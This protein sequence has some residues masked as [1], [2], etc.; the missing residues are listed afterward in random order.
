[1]KNKFTEYLISRREITEAAGEGLG[2]WSLRNREP[3]GIIAVEHGLISGH[4]VDEILD[5]QRGSKARFG[6]L[7]VEMG[8]LKDA[9]VSWLIEVQNF[10]AVSSVAEALA[11]SGLMPFNNAARLLADFVT[12]HANR[13]RDSQAVPAL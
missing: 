11:L 13:E 8:L 4:Q 9:E 2:T 3:I 1:V 5:R 6:E 7:A 12:E 10:R